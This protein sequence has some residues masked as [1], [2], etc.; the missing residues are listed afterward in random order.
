[1]KFARLGSAGHET[2]AAIVDNDGTPVCYDL[3]PL[4]NDIDGAFF[5]SGGVAEARRALTVGALTQIPDAAG[6]RVGSAIARPSSIICIGMNYAAHAAESGS[7]PPEVPIIF[8]KTANTIAGPNDDVTIPKG[9]EKTDWEVEL[10]VV[11]GKRTSYLDSPADSIRHIAG[12]VTANDLSER[13]FQ[14]EVSGGQWS[15]GKSCAGFSPVGPWV[16][17]PDEVEYNN[18]RLRSWVNGEPRQDSR[19]SDFIFD[20]DDIVWHLSQYLVLE[21]GDL[22]MTGTPQGVALSGDYPYLKPG[23]VCEIDVEGLGRQRQKFVAYTS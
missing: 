10:G 1:M 3:S 15:K 16:S 22:I 12:F 19:T 7:A 5:A 23:D 2:P 4:T 8:L 17:T 18:L 21:P 9:S 13:A 20:V 14:L 6:Q 11:I